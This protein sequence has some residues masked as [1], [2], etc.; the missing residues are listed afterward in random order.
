MARLQS[1]IMPADIQH[2]V[3]NVVDVSGDPVDDLVIYVEAISRLTENILCLKNLNREWFEGSGYSHLFSWLHEHDHGKAAWISRFQ[4]DK[5]PSDP[6]TPEIIAYRPH[7]EASIAKLRIA[8]ELFDRHPDAWVQNLYQSAGQWWFSAE[9]V[10][11][12]EHLKTMGILDK[13]R[14]QGK[15]SGYQQ[16]IKRMEFF[17]RQILAKRILGYQDLPVEIRHNPDALLFLAASTLAHDDPYFSAIYGRQRRAIKQAARSM[18][19]TAVLRNTSVDHRG[20][21]RLDMKSRG[22][23][24]RSV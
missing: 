23:G 13:E 17:E 21:L 9:V 12:I 2:L 18:R 14:P 16:T 4:F 5:P 11:H 19:M 22:F 6:M 1:F 7:A 10:C 15:V 3:Y 20:R 24:K 8:Q